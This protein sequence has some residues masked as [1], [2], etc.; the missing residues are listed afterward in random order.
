[1]TLFGNVS[2]LVVCKMIFKILRSLYF[3]LVLH[4]TSVTVLSIVHRNFP[5][6]LQSDYFQ[7][8]AKIYCH[9]PETS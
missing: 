1:M 4:Q 8:Q 9:P 5:Y 3:C 2:I 7:V 6:N